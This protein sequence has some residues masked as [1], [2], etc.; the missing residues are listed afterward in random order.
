MTFRYRAFLLVLLLGTLIPACQSP[1]PPQPTQAPKK[2]APYILVTPDSAST[3]T[4]TPFLPDP[5]SAPETFIPSPMPTATVTPSPQASPISSPTATSTPNPPTSTY[6]VPTLGEYI[7]ATPNF[8]G[9]IWDN[10]PPPIIYPASTQIPYPVGML[11]QPED[12]I[13]ILLLGSD[14]RPNS[15]HYRTDTI[16]LMTINK[17]LGT[18]NRKGYCLCSKL[19]ASS[20]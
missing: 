4:P 17:N 12:Q 14:I 10:Y 2:S 9:G 6:A 16:I 15:T 19:R 11:S 3:I 5:N 8:Y 13:N 1:P 20:A 18:V 7:T